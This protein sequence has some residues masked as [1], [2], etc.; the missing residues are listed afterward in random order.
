MNEITKYKTAFIENKIEII[1]LHFVGTLK[2]G[3]LNKDVRFPKGWKE[4]DNEKYIKENT[5]F[6]NYYNTGVG[7]KT[8]K[9]NNIT[10]VDIDTKDVHKIKIVLQYLNL[11]N[12]NETTCVE[13][14]KGFH[15]YFKYNEKIL[16]TSNF[17]EDIFGLKT[18]DIRNDKALVYAPPTKYE[19]SGIK[20]GYSLYEDQ[21]LD[22]FIE[23]IQGGGII[24][25][26]PDKFIELQ[27]TKEKKIEPVKNVVELLNEGTPPKQTNSEEKKLTEFHRQL[28]NI[29][30]PDSERKFWEVLCIIKRLGYGLTV[31]EEWASRSNH[32]DKNTFKQW[33]TPKWNK[34]NEYNFNEATLKYY[35][36]ETDEKQYNYIK[37]QKYIK[38]VEKYMKN[39]SEYLLSVLF[40][41]FKPSLVCVDHK[42]K[43]FYE[44]NDY[45]KWIEKEKP[46]VMNYLS[47][48]LVPIFDDYYFYR[49]DKLKEIED[50]EERKG[51]EKFL[52]GIKSQIYKLQT[53][54]AK[55]N[56]LTEISHNVYN[57]KILEKLDEENTYLIGF[58]NGAYDLKTSRFIIPEVTDYISM[59]S[60]Y[61][62][63]DEINEKIKE[64]I[65]ETLDKI[66]IME[67]DTNPTELRDY[68]LKILA[69]CLCGYNKYESFYVLTGCGGNGKGL[70]S[71]LIKMTFGEYFGVIDKTFFTTQKKSSSS[72]EPELANKKGL[73][74]LISSECERGEEFQSGKLKLLSGNDTIE[75]RGLYNSPISFIPQFT[76]LFEVNGCP[77]LSQIDRGIKR[78]FKLIEHPVQFV[79]N[80]NPE[81]KWEQKRNSTIKEK[82][83]TD[84][85]YRMQFMLILIEYYNKYIKDDTSSEIPTPECVNEYTKQFLHENDYIARFFDEVGIEITN[86]KKDQIEQKYI[87]SA[88]R[89][90][91]VYNDDDIRK[92]RN[93]LYKEVA[94]YEGIKKI[95]T[96]GK[97]YF[98]GLKI[99]NAIEFYKKYE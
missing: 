9:E 22:S 95:K 55:N 40:K 27:Q 30:K 8:G 88:F 96:Q 60:G 86:G 46:H 14:N 49:K 87:W 56:Y 74:V 36:R 1:P 57:K 33:I 59:S 31:A 16:T 51:Q 39:P 65:L 34:A 79:E 81:N 58:E 29:V 92:K 66:Y 67:N 73:R 91:S 25:E 75:T 37:T 23:E 70:L 43:I 17:R 6:Q 32:Y 77:N 80:P 26:I 48:E 19:V 53:A 84:P 10:V 21:D 50:E 2:D 61:Y 7:I 97:Q 62:Y 12:L 35:A 78:R 11:E 98:R 13:T 99:K 54:S 83:K 72:A 94:N 85:R 20:G 90:T 4:Y 18:M 93:E 52:K 42:N 64:E 15:L 41:N 68:I 44:P 71:S 5:M 82:F 45:N 69:S 47:Q 38:Y 28:L 63:T 3:K 76:M 89:E 24:Q